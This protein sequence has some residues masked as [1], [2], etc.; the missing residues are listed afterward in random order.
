MKS[1]NKSINIYTTLA[2]ILSVGFPCGIVGIV[3]GA[4]RHITALLVVGIVFTVLGFYVAPTLWPK[5]S[6]LKF[7]KLLLISIE[8]DKLL[9]VSELAGQYNKKE[10]EIVRNINVL[11][12]KRY[13]TGYLFKDKKVLE[14]NDRQKA[15]T[16]SKC[17]N[18]GAVISEEDNACQYCGYKIYGK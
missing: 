18:C 9:S 12:E 4:T 5:R 14:P 2:I 7:L 8:N 1:L 11:I 13:L 15:L 3:F 16:K 6:E 10:E 17:P